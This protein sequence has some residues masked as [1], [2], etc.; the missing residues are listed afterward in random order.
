[1]RAAPCLGANYR[2][3]GAR[4]Q[5]GEGQRK[6]G[7]AAPADDCLAIRTASHRRTM[8]CLADATAPYSG[9]CLFRESDS[10]GP[11]K[12]RQT[13]M[14]DEV[15]EPLGPAPGP[16]AASPGGGFG[17]MG[18]ALVAASVLAAAISF[19]AP[20]R[21]QASPNRAPPAAAKVEIPPA[22]PPPSSARPF[23]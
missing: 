3:R 9:I 19:L 22:P 8:L 7:P 11:A 23:P 13:E 12:G 6:T 1:M 17:G 16:T 4:G 10:R 21:R 14:R 5:S 15:N 20:E 18:R 2:K